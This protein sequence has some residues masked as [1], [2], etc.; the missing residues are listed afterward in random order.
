MRRLALIVCVV[1]VAYLLGSVAWQ[2]SRAD[3]AN[4][5]LRDEMHDMSSQLGARI[6]LNPASSDDDFRNEI[7]RKAGQ[8]GIHLLPT[9]VIVLRKGG[10]LDPTAQIYLAADYTVPIRLPGISFPRHY[11]PESG[12][13][14]ASAPQVE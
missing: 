1:V 10:P 12:P 13:K 6:G 9:Q 14:P 5:Q 7:L 8:H 11:Q 2:I 4:T 3:L